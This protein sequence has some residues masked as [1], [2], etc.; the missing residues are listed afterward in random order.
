MP[1]KSLSPFNKTQAPTVKKIEIRP[2]KS[3]A[4]VATN[5]ARPA[6]KSTK[7]D[8][9]NILKLFK[10]LTKSNPV[11]VQMLSHEHINLKGMDR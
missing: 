10:Y 9:N 7:A 2:S 5:Q 8:S 3:P 1:K 6:A 4:K 11:N